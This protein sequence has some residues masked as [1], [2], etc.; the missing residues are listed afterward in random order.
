MD[1]RSRRIA[2]T[3]ITDPR[4]DDAHIVSVARACSA[5]FSGNSGFAVQLRDRT[6]RSDE[7]LFLLAQTLREIA[8]LLI[9]NRRFDLARR[10]RA[11]GVHAPSNELERARDFSFRS[12][13]AHSDEEL[14]NATIATC[15][16][17]SPIFAVPGKIAARGLDAIRSARALAP[18]MT[19]VALGGID[20]SNARAC[21]EAGADGVA[22]MRALLDASDPAEVAQRLLT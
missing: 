5:L 19:I 1:A 20:A 21:F 10:I 11:D 14:Q 22:V 17:I 15:A 13:P 6:D 7:D 16:L 12:A 8:P 4:Y 2:L 18:A 3:L 9:V